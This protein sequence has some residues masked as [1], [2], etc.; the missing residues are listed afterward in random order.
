MANLVFEIR[1]GIFQLLITLKV[2]TL[3]WEKKQWLVYIL[4]NNRP[5]NTEYFGYLS[6]V[7]WAYE[8][9]KLPMNWVGSVVESTTTCGRWPNRVEFTKTAEFGK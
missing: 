8:R 3:L 1:K 9:Q 4:E 5:M 7:F 6:G 2:E